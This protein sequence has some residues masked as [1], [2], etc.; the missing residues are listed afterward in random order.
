MGLG[1]WY[2]I[3][4]AA[5]L[6]VGVGI[7]LGSLLPEGRTGLSAGI[8]AALGVAAGI[9]IGR[10]VGGWPEAAGGGSGG[11]LGA[12]SSVPIVAGALRGGGTRLGVAALVALT[13]LV[14]AAL[15]LVPGLGYAEAVAAPL[16]AL[17][18]RRRGARR[19]AGLRILAKD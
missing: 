13:G 5:G 16:V 10:L 17:R 7:A 3:G 9:G 14:V 1:S 15:G 2:W 18:L 6:G 8:A 11:L 4:L 19:Y 12:V